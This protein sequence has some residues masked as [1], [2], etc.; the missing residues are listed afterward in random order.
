MISPDYY[1]TVYCNYLSFMSF[2]QYGRAAVFCCSRVNCGVSFFLLFTDMDFASKTS[3]E[4]KLVAKVI[5]A[6]PAT[7]MVDYAKSLL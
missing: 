1:Y 4:F 6:V 5:F 3:E 2:I 7:Q